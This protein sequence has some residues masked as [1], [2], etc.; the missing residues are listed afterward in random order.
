MT[1]VAAS[2]RQVYSVEEVKAKLEEWRLKLLAARNG[3]N[4]PTTRQCLEHLDRWL[5]ELSEVLGR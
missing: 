3:T 2:A 5:D 4:T 1:I